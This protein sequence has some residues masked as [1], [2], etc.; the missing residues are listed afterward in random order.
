MKDQLSHI[1]GTE[2]MLLGRNGPPAAP[3]GLPHVHNP[4]GKMNEAWIQARRTTPGSE[5]LA[6]FEALAK[7]RLQAMR[8]M[9][10]EDLERGLRPES[11]HA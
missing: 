1:V 5:V 11:R 2:S 10:D 7:E 9:S 4:I 8:A 6:E 3:A